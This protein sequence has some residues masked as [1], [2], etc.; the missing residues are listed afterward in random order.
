M[1]SKKMKKMKMGMASMGGAMASMGGMGMMGSQTDPLGLK[2]PGFISAL[3]RHIATK[4]VKRGI[5]KAVELTRLKEDITITN[6]VGP[7]EEIEIPLNK[8][9]LQQISQRL[10]DLGYYYEKNPESDEIEFTLAPTYMGLVGQASSKE[11]DS[12]Q[13]AIKRF[14]RIHG[15]SPDKCNGCIQPEG[16]TLKNLNSNLRT[17][18]SS[19]NTSGA[20]S[21]FKFESE[22]GHNHLHPRLWNFM[23]DIE[24]FY[25]TG[26]EKWKKGK[27][28][29]GKD[30]MGSEMYTN[31]AR[32]IIIS[33]ASRGYPDD[34]H[35]N[36]NSKHYEALAL[37]II[38]VNGKS[39][40]DAPRELKLPDYIGS[41]LPP[42]MQSMYLEQMKILMALIMGPVIGFAYLLAEFKEVGG[43]LPIKWNITELDSPWHGDTENHQD[44]IHIAIE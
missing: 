20:S 4:Q 13:S 36:V 24:W 42:Q 30:K 19:Y 17:S 44:Y 28:G 31:Y 38:S 32:E 25:Q 10:F 43:Q 26:K 14:Q 34:G 3:S 35:K 40:S 7:P 39:V 5:G 15:F 21:I 22:K 41:K 16:K 1:G 8:E 11:Q 33:Y 2:N 12:L 29:K 27:H 37:D 6:P 18:L 9:D 23:D